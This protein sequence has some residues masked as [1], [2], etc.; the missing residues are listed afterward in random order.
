[1]STDHPEVKTG[2]RF[3]LAAAFMIGTAILLPAVAIAGDDPVFTITFNDGE[4]SPQRLEVPAEK[5]FEIRLINNGRTPAEFESVPLSKEK[6]IGPGVTTFIVIKYLD[7][8][9]YSFF[10]DFHPGAPPA[11]LIAVPTE[12]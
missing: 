6:V 1:V 11:V 10:D 12:D 3:G 7:P 8:G 5:R 4:V 9:E 2:R